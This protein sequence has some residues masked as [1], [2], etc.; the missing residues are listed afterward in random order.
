M[1]NQQEVKYL[2]IDKEAIPYLFE[3]QVKEITYEIQ[4]NYNTVGE[5]FTL[6]LYKNKEL[7][8]AGEKLVY[9]K[10]LFD[11]SQHKEIPKETIIPYDINEE[12]DKVTYEN[13]NNEVMLYIL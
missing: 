11:T 7:L 8:V 4:V 13:L 6:D 10:P 1:V 2:E 9:G 12:V 3:L 5:F